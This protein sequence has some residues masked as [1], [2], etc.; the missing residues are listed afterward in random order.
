MGVTR[1]VVSDWKSR[2]EEQGNVALD[3]K[4]RRRRPGE[5]KALDPKQ[6]AR[7]PRLVAD[8]C[9][10]QL[11]LEFALSTRVPIATLIQRKTGVRLSQSAVGNYLR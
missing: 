8:N 11:K 6:E 2:Y 1:Q 7:I 5:R 9:P 3:G 10:C 4:T